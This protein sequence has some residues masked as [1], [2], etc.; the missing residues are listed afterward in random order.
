MSEAITTTA[1]T[2]YNK[3]HDATIPYRWKPGQS[4]NPAGRKKG[5]KQKLAEVFVAALQEDFQKNGPAVIAEVRQNKPADYLRIIAAVI[6][7]EFNI[8]DM[9]VDQLTDEELLDQLEALRSVLLA[10]VGG[11]SNSGIIEATAEEVTDD[12]P[13]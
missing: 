7:K 12:Q 11:T 2:K 13:A 5:S 8:R 9:A 1:S 6:P 3:G 4:G 10:T